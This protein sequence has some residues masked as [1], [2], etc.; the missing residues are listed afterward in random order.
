MRKLAII[1]ILAIVG[2]CKEPEVIAPVNPGVDVSA[3]F[4]TK[5]TVVTNAQQ[6]K[7]N[8]P[9]DGACTLTIIDSLSKQV[10]TREKLVGKL[11][12]NKV[13]I[14]TN[15]LPKGSLILV[16]Q[17]SNKGQLGRALIINK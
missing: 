1:F 3:V 14:Y 5:Q 7:F 10:V 12:E 17:D 16:L 6:I 15:T 9:A 11:G 13:K 2:S 4:S 8:L